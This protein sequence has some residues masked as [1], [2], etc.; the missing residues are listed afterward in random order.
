[1]MASRIL[2]GVEARLAKTDAMLLLTCVAAMGAM[3][4]IYLST[5][6]TPEREIG[7]ITAGDLV[8]GDGGGCAAQ[9]S[10][11]PDVRRPHRA[12]AVDR[13]TAPAR[14]LWRAAA[15]GRHRLAAALG[16]AV[17]RRHRRDVGRSFSPIGR[18]RTCWPRYSAARRAHGAPP[19]YLFRVVLG[20]VL[21]GL[22]SRRRGCAGVWQARREPGARFLLAW[23]VP[24][25]I[26]F[27]VVMTK[28]PHYVLPLYP[29]IAILIAGVVERHALSRRLWLMRGTVS[30]FA[31]H[32]RCRDAGRR[33]G[34]RLFRAG[35]GL[36]AWPFRRPR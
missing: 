15:G 13:S 14:W 25:W 8:D 6:R 9:G 32:A 31:D 3:A 7:W 35:T 23:L 12:D 21:A 24:S 27:E 16:A 2:L 28:L 29:A 34:E 17:V 19:G 20:D 10:A 33:D 26:V 18:R 4:R 22:D 11:D 30:W 1:M 36:L 5:R